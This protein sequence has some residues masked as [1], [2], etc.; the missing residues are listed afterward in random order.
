MG[1]S[2]SG[3]SYFIHSVSFISLYLSF[4]SSLS[5][6]LSLS[7]ACSVSRTRAFSLLLPVSAAA[8]LSTATVLFSADA[9]V[10]AGHGFN[11]RYLTLVVVVGAVVVSNYHSGYF[12]SSPTKKVPFLHSPSPSPSDP[13]SSEKPGV[14]CEAAEEWSHAVGGWGCS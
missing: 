10:M 6:F 1:Q 14:C 7:C 11:Y 4:S 12:C 3:P 13:T 8:H 2:S 9:P 5:F